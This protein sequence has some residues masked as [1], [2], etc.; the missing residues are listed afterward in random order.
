MFN[1]STDGAVRT[2]SSGFE[3]KDPIRQILGLFP[4]QNSTVVGA[5]LGGNVKS[6]SNQAEEP[7]A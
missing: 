5:M 6:W 7:L 2:F 1:M 3:K 4:V